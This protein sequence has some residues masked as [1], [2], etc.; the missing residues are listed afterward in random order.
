MN[1][2]RKPEKAQILVY[3]LAFLAARAEV[4]GMHPFAIAIFA[5]A[6]LIG[7][8]SWGLYGT[9]LLGLASTLSLTATI[10]YAG[11]LFLTILAIGFVV[12]EGRRKNPVIIAGLA[13]GITM[14]AG[15]VFRLIPA[16][17]ENPQLFQ[18]A[19]EQLFPEMSMAYTGFLGIL[20]EHTQAW[21]MPIL[22]GIMV[23]CFSLVLEQA[24]QVIDKKEFIMR[25]ENLLSSVALTAVVL[26]GVPLQIGSYLTILQGVV[27]YLLL[28]MS[29]RY[30]ISYGTSLGTVCGVILAIK[31]HQV[32]W[33]A[34]CV[35]LSLAAAFLG[36]WSKWLAFFGFFAMIGFLGWFYYPDLLSVQA[37]RGLA[38]AGI[39]FVLTPKSY[40]LKH[41]TDTPNE[42]QELISGEV[43]K[44]T[45]SRLQEFADV[46]TKI[47]QSFCE[48]ACAVEQGG[49]ALVYPFFARQMGEIG[50]SLREFSKGMNTAGAVNEQQERRLIHELEHQ[51]VRVQ[52]VIVMQGRQGRQ[53]IYLSAR[54]VR[55]RV[56]T[57]KEAAEI[58]SR[59]FGTRYRVAPASRLI[60]NREYDVVVF[61]EDT[62]YHYL[63]GA[64]RVAKDGQ[65]IS[66]DNF[67]Q[68]ELKNGQLLMMLADGMGSGETANHQ[69]EQLV[70]LLEE[71]LEAGFRKESAVE[72]L[73]E[74]IAVQNQGEQFATLDMCMIDLYSGVGEFLKMGASTTYIKRGSWME[75]IQSTTLPVGIQERTEIDTVRKKLYHGDMVIMVSDGVL[76]GIRFE[77]KEECLKEMIQEMQ[78]RNPQEMADEIVRQV[79]QMNG[80][81]LRDDASVLVV[82][83]WKK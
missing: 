32:E 73:N 11:I 77:N 36:E 9:V 48:P 2:E 71:M 12:Q 55:G 19:K 21:Y 5:G 60:I 14:L 44:M 37:F 25:S 46:F 64:K 29:Y 47:S 79:R 80:G 53:E 39:L 82:G 83:I 43:Q 8:G 72:I 51:N 54:T 20:S 24:L 65:L 30:G 34:I 22:E 52:H 38:S 49:Q 56:M 4:A 41:R 15:L 31:T 57:A 63:T 66:G 74:L 3:I 70:D 42:E 50:E 26:W 62:R 13:G 76:D 35:M 33:I 61:E 6:Y 17:G 28:Y 40:L 10:K 59:S 78:V 45:R 58:V 81:H 68:M 75:S 67:S 18:T 7:C 1:L 27:F 16:W 23:A 69:S